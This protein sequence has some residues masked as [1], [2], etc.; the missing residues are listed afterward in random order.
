VNARSI[1]RRHVFL[2]TAVSLVLVAAGALADDKADCLSGIEMLKAEI[3]KNP[4]KPLLDKLKEALGKAEQE[5]IEADWDECLDAVEE[6]KEALS[7]T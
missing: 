2:V 4:A 7:R 6:A 3:A 5:A 1:M